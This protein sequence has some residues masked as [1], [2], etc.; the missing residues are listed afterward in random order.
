ME[1]RFAVRLG[2]MMAQAEMKPDLLKGAL[3]RLEKFM[4]PFTAS[5]EH[6]VQ[7]QHAIEYVTGLA[8]NIPRKNVEMIA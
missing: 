1:Q 7:M 3:E 2:Q 6:P 8:S 4:E 5:L